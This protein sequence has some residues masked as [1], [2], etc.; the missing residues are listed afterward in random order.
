MQIVYPRTIVSTPSRRGESMGTRSSHGD[1]A[2]PARMDVPHPL[3]RTAKAETAPAAAEGYSGISDVTS[4]SS[5]PMP[6]SIA[7]LDKTHSGP[8]RLRDSSKA[9]ASDAPGD[10]QLPAAEPCRR[11][12]S[13]KTIADTMLSL[14]VAA[15]STGDTVE[16]VEAESKRRRPR[17]LTPRSGSTK[18]DRRRVCLPPVHRYLRRVRPNVPSAPRR[19]PKTAACRPAQ[20][21]AGLG[22]RRN[23]HLSLQRQ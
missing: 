9:R 3:P 6:P 17:G 5:A 8:S 2:R 7:E 16:S 14:A 11:M 13:T 1:A 20:C 21:P 10:D 15:P 23:G 18:V 12:G 4:L 22:G 19:R